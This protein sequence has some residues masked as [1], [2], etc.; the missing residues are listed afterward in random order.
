MIETRSFLHSGDFLPCGGGAE[1]EVETWQICVV[2]V[3]HP[4]HHRWAFCM[5]KITHQTDLETSI[6]ATT[7]QSGRMLNRMSFVHSHF[8]HTKA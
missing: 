4:F 7:R 5:R 6:E 3:H 1:A 8:W 2:A